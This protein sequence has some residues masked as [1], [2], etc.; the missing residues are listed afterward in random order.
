M[1]K[2]C[3]HGN[4]ECLKSNSA[5]KGLGW[6]EGKWYTLYDQALIVELE[7]GVRFIANFKYYVDP[8]VAKSPKRSPFLAGSK[9]VAPDDEE[10]FDK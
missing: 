7:T 2:Q 1:A 6:E 10:A 8:E 9:P 5:S 3:K 4:E